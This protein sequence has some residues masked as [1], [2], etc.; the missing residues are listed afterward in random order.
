MAEENVSATLIVAAPVT[1]VFAVLADPATH[2]AIDGTGWV[3][4]AAD[5]APLTEVGQ[6]FRMDM[7][8]GAHPDG[9][10]QVVNKVAGARRA[11]GHR[12]ADRVPRRTTASWSSA[13]GP[14]GTTSRRAVRPRPRSSSPTT[15][16]RC[17]SSIRDR[18]IQ[19]PPFGPEHLTELA[20]ATWP[21][22]PQHR[23][24]RTP[25]PTH[26]PPVTYR[27]HIRIRIRTGNTAPP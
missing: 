9:D 5:R 13:A 11:A 26:Y 3:Q 23:P 16:R 7:H 27:R 21:S 12:L 19:F 14:G 10:Y 4:E 17:R 8:H 24:R 18:G 22:S 6:L 2:A 25:E 15:G 20:A 1:R